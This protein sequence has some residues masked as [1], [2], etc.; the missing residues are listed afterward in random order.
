MAENNSTVTVDKDRNKAESNGVQ[1]KTL[2]PL[3]AFEKVTP[4]LQ[5]QLE[6]VI[7]SVSMK[8]WCKGVIPEEVHDKLFDNDYNGSNSRSNYFVTRLYKKIKKA[9]KKHPNNK[10]AKAIIKIVADA[11]RE[12]GA[13]NDAADEISKLAERKVYRSVYNCIIFYRR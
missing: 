6:L 8:L 13:L 2:T 5:L 7:G 4:I 11:L 10:E 3:E 12:D 9:E 1:K